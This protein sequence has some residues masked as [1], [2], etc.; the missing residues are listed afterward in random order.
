VSSCYFSCY[1]VWTY[2]L[3]TRHV[4]VFAHTVSLCYMLCSG[5]RRSCVLMLLCL[6]MVLHVL[7]P[8]V[9]C[10]VMVLQILCPHVA[11]LMMVLQVL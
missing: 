7:C 9:T 8:H 2:H 4:I 11:C 1:G 6:V 5:V 3:P 10:L